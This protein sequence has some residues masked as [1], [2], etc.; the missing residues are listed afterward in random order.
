MGVD[1]A[2]E[3][4]GR[5]QT[6]MQCTQSVR[7]GGKAVMIGLAI[8]GSKG[9]IDINHLV[10]RQVRIFIYFQFLIY[11]LLLMTPSTLVVCYYLN[12]PIFLLSMVQL[13]KTVVKGSHEDRTFPFQVG[14]HCKSFFVVET[15]DIL[16][17]ILSAILLL[18]RIIYIYICGLPIISPQSK[19]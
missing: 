17:L 2:V 3:A 11:L 9:E 1:I 12:V 10:R 18:I 19:H 14:T 4:L 13:R 8:A 6:F 7:D 16:Y 15:D 5:P